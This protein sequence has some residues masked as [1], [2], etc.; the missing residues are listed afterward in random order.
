MVRGLCEGTS[1][2]SDFLFS[3]Q[4]SRAACCQASGAMRPHTCGQKLTWRPNLCCLSPTCISP[5][6]S[7]Q[8]G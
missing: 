1:G 8:E 6:Y 7:D 2:L 5:A 4:A 3:Q